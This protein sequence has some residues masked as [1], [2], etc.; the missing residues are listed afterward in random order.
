MARPAAT[1]QID[2]AGPSQ[3]TARYSDLTM[4]DDG[5]G[6]RRHPTLHT[7][8]MARL[9]AMLGRRDATRGR[10]GK[11]SDKSSPLVAETDKGSIKGSLTGFEANEGPDPSVDRAETG[12]FGTAYRIPGEMSHVSQPRTPSTSRRH[13]RQD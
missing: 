3:Q 5:R 6:R 10:R 8:A 1:P 13:M 11:S 9:D 4:L 2:H 7:Q 12:E